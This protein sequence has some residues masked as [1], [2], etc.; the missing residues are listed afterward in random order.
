MRYVIIPDVHGRDFWKKAI[1][2]QNND[3]ELVFLGDYFDP[4]DVTPAQAIKNFDEMMSSLDLEGCE[5]LLGNHDY[6]YILD[7]FPKASRYSSKYAD[8]IKKRIKTL[9]RKYDACDYTWF[10]IN[11]V[12]Y[13]LTHAG[14]N[15]VWLNRHTD[16]WS[17]DRI[18]LFD[19]KDPNRIFAAGEVGKIRGGW[20]KTGGYLWADV[21]E[22]D[23]PDIP[24][25]QIFGHTQLTEPIIKDKWACLDCQKIFIVD[26]TGL[27]EYREDST[28]NN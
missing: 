18:G 28:S 19:P 2:L 1:P 13:L 7:F 22:M 23:V 15:K 6:H 10:T 24:Y 3:T 4:Y 26:E 20:Y 16:L 21:H 9:V 8:E 5:F 17:L 27:H 11:H 12:S 14:I 25:Y